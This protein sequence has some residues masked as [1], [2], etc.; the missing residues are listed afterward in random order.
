MDEVTDL[1]S[2]LRKHVDVLAELI[3]ER[4]TS[5][6]QALQLAR[7][8]IQ[9]ELVAMGH[10]VTP[11]PFKVRSRPAVNYEVFL[12]G[13]RSSKPT[14]VIGAHYD[15]AVGTPG[16]DDNASAVAILLEIS[17]ALAGRKL[18]RNVRIVFYDCE[19]APHF[20]F[21]EMGSQF[22]AAGLRS[23]GEALMGMICLES[24]GYFTRDPAVTLIATLP[25]SAGQCRLQRLFLLRQID[26]L[27]VD[28]LQDAGSEEKVQRR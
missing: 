17:R 8:Y 22:H 16:A 4:N 25:A 18:R 11:Q 20:N 13:R 28:R 21:A 9:R 1:T 14:L 7:D 12:P 23:K 3:G 10:A 6:P 5:R 19:E 15:S 26:L 2:R 24:L 27:F